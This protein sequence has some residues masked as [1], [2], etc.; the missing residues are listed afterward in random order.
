M[1]APL[2]SYATGY[3]G[4]SQC[5]IKDLPATGVI[6]QAESE[7]YSLPAL[8]AALSVTEAQ[9]PPPTGL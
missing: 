9:F 8:K 4:M 5:D 2:C 1:I 7:V 6:Y 3:H